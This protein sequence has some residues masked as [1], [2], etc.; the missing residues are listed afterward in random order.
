MRHKTQN[1]A[2]QSLTRKWR[3]QGSGGSM[4]VMEGS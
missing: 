4:A 1:G 2:W 3:Y